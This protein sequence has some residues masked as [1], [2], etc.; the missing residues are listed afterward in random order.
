MSGGAWAG[1]GDPLVANICPGTSC[2]DA[3]L[4]AGLTFRGITEIVAGTCRRTPQH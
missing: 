1:P 4:D 2:R 3:G